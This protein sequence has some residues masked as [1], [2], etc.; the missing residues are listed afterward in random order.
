MNEI[1]QSAVIGRETELAAISQFLETGRPLHALLLTGGPGI[2]KTTLW[3]AG[4]EAGRR[5]AMRVLVSRRSSAEGLSFAGLIDLLDGIDVAAL[6]GLAAPQA[7]AL[8][9]ALLREEPDG[10]TAPEAAGVGFLSALRILAAREPLLVAID[11]VQWLDPPSAE[12]LAFAARRLD[13]SSVAFLL[14]RRRGRASTLEQ[15]LDQRYLERLEVAPLSLGAIR[16][17]LSQRLGLT[18]PRQLVRRIAD[19][20]LGNPLFALEVGRTLAEQGLP[21]I[22]AELPL[23][24]AIEELLDTRVERLPPSVRRVLLAIA[25]NGD[26]RR[27]ELSALTDAPALDDGVEAGVLIVDRDLVR[28]SHPLIG[29]AARK[30]SRAGERRE[31]HLE[32]AGVVANEEQRARHLALGTPEPDEEVA[33]RVGSA[34]DRASARGASGVAAELGEHALRLTRRGSQAWSAR[35]LAAAEYLVQAGEPQRATELIR[36][37]TESL[38]TGTPRARAWIIRAGGAIRNSDEIAQYFEHAL[39]ESKSEPGLHASVLARIVQNTVAVRVERIAEAEEWAVTALE[40]AR[41]AGPQAEQL[42]LYA[43]AWAR[44]LRGRAIDDICRRF[45]AICDSGFPLSTSPERIAGQRFAWR[46]QLE[47]ARALLER[48]L[49][50]SDERGESYS[51]ALIRLHLC[52]LEQRT[53]DWPAAGRLLDEWAADRE[54]L[55]W[56]MYQ[57]CQ[58]LTAAGRGLPDDASRWAADTLERAE[59]TGNRWDRLE[60]LRA[61]GLAALLAHAPDAAAQ[62]LREV[63]QHGE[64]E[65]VEEPGAF[66]VAPSLVEA[67]SELGEL[68]EARSVT[69]RLGTLARRQR[70]PWAT[71][72]AQQCE[73]VVRL[74]AD[75]EDDEAAAQLELAATRFGVLGLRFDGARATLL[76]GRFQRRRRKWAA[77]RHA[78]E[79]AAN[80]FDGLGSNGWADVARSELSRISGRR[81]GAAGELTEA[82]RRVAELAA[83]GLANKEI[84]QTLFV[85]VHTIEA[86]LSKVYAKLGIRSRAQLAGRLAR[87]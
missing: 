25:L 68:D 49:E 27:S 70:H 83:E 7:H 46:G 11:D 82:E 73:A 33:T 57:R 45:G 86:H 9:V 21:T 17:L 35:L 65:G 1:G 32:L 72:A 31:L 28:A 44:S 12:A 22:G 13:G 67:L 37:E 15:V 48:L 84:A 59:E 36:P 50:L 23:P 8:Q 79:C 81:S 53:G 74:V 71:A 64:R 43:L 42:P 39:A 77:A 30:H 40:T 80:A 55:T 38:P 58:A 3:E 26:L 20:T 69:R 87:A 4:V 14:T 51:Y 41:P 47:E 66:P 76:L 54:V 6:S 61:Q 18:L 34:A 29:A 5:H 75:R 56:P 52:Q 63:W 85:S 10:S 24:D 78:L 62:C 19:A 60:A 2:G 16:Y